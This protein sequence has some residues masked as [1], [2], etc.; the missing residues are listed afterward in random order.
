MI[1]SNRNSGVTV[2]SFYS[3]RAVDLSLQRWRASAMWQCRN[4]GKRGHCPAQDEPLRVH[5][6]PLRF[7]TSSPKMMPI[8]GPQD[9]WRAPFP[10]AT[11]SIPAFPP[12]QEWGDIQTRGKSKAMC[13]WCKWREDPVLCK[14]QSQAS[15]AL[16]QTQKRGARS[17]RLALGGKAS[18]GGTGALSN[19]VPNHHLKRHQ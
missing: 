5:V 17:R 2:I 10:E 19:V 9:L 4:I 12:K 14:H 1:H 13:S 18:S 15:R 3:P 8:P 6:K 7:P 11:F 16:P